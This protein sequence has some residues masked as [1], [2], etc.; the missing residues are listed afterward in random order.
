M[1]G[2]SQDTRL[3]RDIEARL[4]KMNTDDEQ[5]DMRIREIGGKLTDLM[6]SLSVLI[7]ITAGILVTLL[8][9]GWGK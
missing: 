5:L 8:V 7:F 3:L 1:E 4:S 6:G 9:R 2:D